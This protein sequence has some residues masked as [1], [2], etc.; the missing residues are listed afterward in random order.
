LSS[1]EGPEQLNNPKTGQSFIIY[2]AA[3]SDNR[4]YFLG[5]LELVGEDPMNPSEWK[6]NEADCVF[7]QGPARKSM[8]SAMRASQRVQRAARTDR[9][10]W[11]EEI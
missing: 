5:Q 6:K 3:R 1:N 8:A 10:L 2:S 4:D 7:Y 9:I 11:D